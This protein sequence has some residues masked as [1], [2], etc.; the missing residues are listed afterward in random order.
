MAFSKADQFDP[1]L[2]RQTF[3]SKALGHPARIIIL[4]YLLKSKTGRLRDFRSQINLTPSTISQHIRY[5]QSLGVIFLV[6]KFPYGV[7]E[8]DK[9][10][11][12]SLVKEIHKTNYRFLRF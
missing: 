8:I 6:A 5:L 2:I 12:R 1:A 4:Q 10:I 7:Y 3:W 9:T 11:C